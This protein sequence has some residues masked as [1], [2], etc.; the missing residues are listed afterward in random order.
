MPFQPSIP[1]PEPTTE[2][3]R[4]FIRNSPPGF[5]P[6]NQDSNLGQFRKVVTD[7]LQ[8][9]ADEL[10]LIW[11]EMDLRETSQFLSKWEELLGVPIEPT[12]KTEAERRAIL[13]SR[14]VYGAFTRAVRNLQVEK[15]L[16]PT[17]S[18]GPPIKLLPAGVPIPADGIPIYGEPADD[19]KTLY[20]IYEDILNFSYEVF[21]N[22]TNGVDESALMRALARQTPAGVSFTIDNSMVEILYWEKMIR[23]QNPIFHS[24]FNAGWTDVSGF[25]IGITP[26][27]SPAAVASPGLLNG[28]INEVDGARDFNG[29]TQYATVD[30]DPLLRMQ[31]SGLS[32]SII[33]NADTLPSIG[34][35]YT[36]FY[37]DQTFRLRMPTIAGPITYFETNIWDGAA[38]S[39]SAIWEGI[40]TATTYLV[41]VTW[42]RVKLRLYVNGVLQSTV[43]AEVEPANVAQLTYIGSGIG[44]N[45]FDGKLDEPSIYNYA[46]TQGQITEQYKTMTAVH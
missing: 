4:S 14:Y 1:D 7:E 21:I 30:D 20:R 44:T 39:N 23:N 32:L 45:W 17:I 29:S 13:L 6:T 19:P 34:A 43:D 2:L 8:A 16:A 22:S 3:E 24:R 42:D 38:W 31:E 26:N 15:L 9:R 11:F 40:A 25:G 35:A 46:L 37:R 12:G 10:T 18:G 5:F 33:L 41:N 27:G 28:S 36:I